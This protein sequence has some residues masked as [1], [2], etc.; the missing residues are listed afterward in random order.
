MGSCF[1]KLSLK[2]VCAFLISI[3]KS[4]ECVVRFTSFQTSLDWVPV[5]EY[6][7]RSNYNQSRKTT[8]NTTNNSDHELTD[9]GKILKFMACYN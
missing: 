4:S 3:Y 9:I 7:S 5:S 8:N 2:K 6:N 1:S